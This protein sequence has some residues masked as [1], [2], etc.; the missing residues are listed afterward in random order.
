MTAC[1]RVICLVRAAAWKRKDENIRDECKGGRGS[2]ARLGG[3]A[4]DASR[5]FVRQMERG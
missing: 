3:K 1:P 2:H 4:C 5:D